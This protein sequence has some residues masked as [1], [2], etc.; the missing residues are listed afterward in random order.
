MKLLTMANKFRHVDSFDKASAAGTVAEN[1]IE[2]AE[3]IVIS[4]D[5]VAAA[6][7]QLQ[8]LKVV[9]NMPG[10]HHGPLV[11][12][13]IKRYKQF[14]MPLV[15]ELGQSRTL[16]PP[17]DVQWVWH[18][19]CLNP[20]A[21]RRYCVSRFARI[22]DKPLLLEPKSEADSL[23]RCRKLWSERFPSEPF[24]L[25]LKLRPGLNSSV[26]H[27]VTICSENKVED[28]DFDLVAAISS[29]SSLYQQQFFQPFMW[30]NAFLVAAKERYKCF[31]HLVNKYNEIFKACV[32]TFDIILMWAAH[33]NSPVAYARDV[34]WIDGVFGGAAIT[35]G[36]N[37]MS[38]EDLHE[39]ARLWEITYGRPY[40]K[41]GATFDSI[42]S[43]PLP[44]SKALGGL[45]NP[46]PMHWEYQEIDVNKKHET[47]EPRHVMEVCVLIKGVANSHKNEEFENLTLR[48]QVLESY[49]RLRLDK[50]LA[51]LSTATQWQKPW[52][53]QCE[54]STRGLVLELRSSMGASC[55][56]P[57]GR[58]R[59]LD[60]LVFLWNEI[61]QAPS[62]TL[63]KTITAKSRSLTL[64][65]N[66]DHHTQIQIITSIT[67]PVQAP[68]LL[69]CVPDRVTDDSGAMISD[70]VLRM[71]KK[72]PQEG[73]W[74]SRTVLNHAGKECF[75]V[76]IR[77]ARGMWRR[78]G[79]RPVGVDWN[80]RVIQ[81]CE[82]TWT[83]V[84]GSIGIAPAN[85]VGTATPIADELEHHKMTWSLSSGEI[86]TI[87]MP[88]QQI[89]W[90]RHLEFTL[91]NAPKGKSAR[92]MNGRKLQYEVTG[93]KPEEEEGFVTLVRY[94]AQCPQGKATALF[95]WKVSAMEFLPEE[96]AVLVMLLCNATVRT[97]ADFGSDNLGNF[98]IRRRMKEA[99]PRSRDWGSVV[100]Q[101]SP[102]MSDLSFWYLNPRE[103]LG[104]PPVD[105][106]TFPLNSEEETHLYRNGSWL[107]MDAAAASMRR[108]SYDKNSTIRKVASS[109]NAFGV[110][111]A[112]EARAEPYRRSFGGVPERRS[113]ADI[114]SRNYDPNEAW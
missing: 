39:T 75:V 13:A 52:T 27:P 25:R 90:E 77:V 1:D 38:E 98:F 110:T 68:Y 93:A 5:L 24:D 106:Q 78:S 45:D 55:I 80:E 85:V 16:L 33:Q 97:V 92:L 4:V 29:Q 14:W 94:T 37:N 66:T 42:L 41:A 67:P 100:M 53:L 12:Q 91:K 63:D 44:I 61:L 87:Q 56:N 17:L 103:V 102:W 74:I 15:A 113:S 58:S 22:I 73:R 99:K 89:Q 43:T 19:H 48:L 84:S 88:I 60:K 65:S 64:N 21:Y 47:L 86:F 83:Y 108:S 2:A 6:T 95:N 46:K 71:N 49:K 11:L 51:E 76:R 3:N 57:L 50:H 104:L 23:Y 70:Y 26:V 34:E 54:V 9:G 96:D 30:E 28:D 20:D 111:V 8:F 59:S 40:E 31:L 114:N 107:Y 62:L 69:K 82:G 101:N 72:R 32:P 105:E 18:C 36:P 81:I 79:D 112:E 10:L 35:R 7:K 109:G